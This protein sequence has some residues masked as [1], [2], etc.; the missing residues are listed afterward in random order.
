MLQIITGKFFTCDELHETLQRAVIYTNYNLIIPI[1]TACGSLLP[2]SGR[3]EV[4]ETV[5]EVNQRLEARFKSGEPSILVA[6]GVEYL[7]Q[8]FAAIVSFIS[9]AT[10]STDRE[11]VRRL[12]QMR[13]APLGVPST[14]NRYVGRVFDSS[15]DFSVEDSARLQSFIRELVGLER[16]DYKRVMRAIRRYITGLHRVGDDLTLAYTLLVASIESLAQDFDQFQPVW[17]DYAREKRGAIDKAL[18]HAPKAVADAVRNAILSIEHVAI[19]RRFREFAIAHVDPSFYREEAVGR[20]NPV[21]CGDLQSCLK[22]AYEIRSKAVHVL[23]EL[24]AQLTLIPSTQDTVRLE[25]RP[26]LTLQGLAHLARHIILTY[27]ARAPKVETEEYDYFPDIPGQVEMPLAEEYWIWNPAG[28]NHETSWQYL[29][30]FVRRLSSAFAVGPSATLPGLGQVLE[31]VEKQV[32]GLSPSRRRSMVALYILF[33]EYVSSD[34]RRPEYGEF[35]ATYAADFDSPSIESLLL[36]TI[37]G[38]DTGWTVEQVEEVR[39]S[40]LEQRH[41]KKGLTF[42]LLLD[43]AITLSLAEMHRAAGNDMRAHE[44]IAAAVEDT[45]G[46]TALWEFEKAC[47]ANMPPINWRSILLPHTTVAQVEAEDTAASESPADTGGADEVSEEAGSCH[48]KTGA[49]IAAPA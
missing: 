25:G 6:T 45:P 18:E 29:N 5:Y 8:D 22:D 16:T 44:L 2:A 47:D 39:N 32:P 30:A 40:Y 43:A 33:N 1:E 41:W 10:F 14:P 35:F 13:N 21:R 3:G 11:L 17:A 36:H 28:F 48:E 34:Q 24:P 20:Q 31:E 15:V 19:S 9:S 46:H 37:F 23:L 42:G 26:L 49:D 7:A 12:T 27:V 38:K 4:T